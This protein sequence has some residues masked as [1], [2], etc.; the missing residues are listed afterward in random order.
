MDYARQQRDPTRHVVGLAFVVIVH[1]LVIWALFSGLGR[2]VVNVIKKPMTATIIDEIKAPPPPPPKKV[3]VPKEKPVETYIP[4]PEVPVQS[5]DT[6]PTITVTTP[7]APPPPPVVA[8]PPAPVV[9]APPPPP[10][11]PK[12]AIRRDI[13]PIHKVD[14]EFPRS[15]IREG[16]EKG[17]V[18][19]RVKIDE[20]G[21][22]T[23]VTIV[24]SEPA[25][26]FDRS[27][28]DALMEWKFKAEGEPY[29][30]E[31]EVTFTLKD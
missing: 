22:V 26:V 16:I 9:V 6:G 10:P 19:A 25:R 17:R 2:T 30:G 18:L 15:A 5:I 4:P 28:R 3:E 23:E 14:P 20:K 7:V 24:S 13:R 21:N 11:P 8:P 27:V 31:V 29:V 12:P 1:G